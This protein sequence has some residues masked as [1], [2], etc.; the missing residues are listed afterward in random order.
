MALAFLNS[1]TKNKGSLLAL[2]LGGRTTKAIHMLRKGDAF[3]LSK[4]GLFD[5]PVS[6]QGLTKELL[7]GHLK[8]I[9]QAMDSKAKNVVVAI[10]VND[11]TVRQAEL[12]LMPVGDMRQ[13]LKMNTKTYL[14]QDLPGHVFDCYIMPPKEGLSADKAK[15][16]GNMPKSKVLVAGAKKQLVDDLQTSI[17]NAGLIPDAI[18][19]SVIGPVNAFEMAHPEP[20]AKEVVALVDIGF[21]N[22]TICLLQEGELV[23]T[24]VV[25]IGGD[26]IT[27]GLAEQMNIGYAEAE[28]IKVGMPS[29]VQAQLEALIAPLGR[30]LR[31]SIDFFEHQQDKT[32]SRV[33]ISGGSARSDFFI[34]LLHNELAIEC[35]SWNPASFLQLSLSPQQLAEIEHVACQLTVAIGTALATL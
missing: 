32:V 26:R 12:P 5:A 28:G 27:Q 4:F 21:K 14:Q 3:I 23:L 22:S 25:N 35:K 13:V 34:Q 2:D 1:V 31:A 29:E 33:F 24:R 6:E 8:T 17:R 18:V 19:P 20:F 7:V 10:D 15:G 30:E 16:A 11:A 9:S